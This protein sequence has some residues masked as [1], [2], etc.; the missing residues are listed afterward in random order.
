[1]KKVAVIIKH[2]FR[3]YDWRVDMVDVPEDTPP[4]AVKDAVMKQMLG[5]FEVIA[6]TDRVDMNRVI[7]LPLAD[8][9]DTSIHVMD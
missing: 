6:V 8:Q 5:P 4:Y 9:P 3:D 1:M 7:E 2:P